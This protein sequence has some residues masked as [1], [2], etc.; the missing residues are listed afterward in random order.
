ML[1]VSAYI[2][3]CV[4]YRTKPCKYFQLNVGYFDNTQGIFSKMKIDELIPKKWRL[5]QRFD[6][7][8]FE[9]ESF[10]VFV[11]PEW[12]QNAA[13]IVRADS[14]PELVDI[15]EQN[16]GS[17]IRYMIQ[18]AAVEKRE[19]EIFAIA[20]KQS[21][22][23]ALTVTEACNET[24]SYPINSIYN[25]ATTYRELTE[26]LSDLQKQNLWSHLSELGFFRIARMSA[27]ADSLQ[28]LCE[29]RFHIIEINLFVP[30]PI[31]LLDP[32]YGS[33]EIVRRVLRY[34]R[35]LAVATRNRDTSQKTRPVFT[36]IMTYN[37]K[38]PLINRFRASI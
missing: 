37:R 16:K 36:K 34:M 15:R 21:S 24:G 1:S 35:S 4:F 9:P 2:L 8:E 17:E 5:S 31:D 22:P 14:M 6:D 29:G 32:R 13:G 3:Y 26:E 33:A 38:S 27:R 7:G 10:P 30:L 23:D 11:K 12:G 25:S 18:Q 20:S 28:D 19:F